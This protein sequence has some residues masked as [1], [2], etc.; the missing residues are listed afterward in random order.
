MISYLNELKAL[1]VEI[2]AESRV[3]MILQSLSELFNQ[4]ENDVA[5]NKKCG[6]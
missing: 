4:F 6:E 1:G 2:N 5:M 3:D